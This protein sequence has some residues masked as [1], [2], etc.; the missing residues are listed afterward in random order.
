MEKSLILLSDISFHTQKPKQYGTNLWHSINTTAKQTELEFGASVSKGEAVEDPKNGKLDQKNYSRNEIHKVYE[1][2]Q[3]L[4]DAK[5]PQ[6]EWPQ[7]EEKK[8]KKQLN[9]KWKW[10]WKPL[11]IQ[12]LLL[13]SSDPTLKS[14]ELKHCHRSWHWGR[15]MWLF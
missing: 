4:R 1:G 10:K 7:R 3:P 13:L 12:S 14:P 11:L 8:N 9:R 2:T 5:A 6:K 15:W